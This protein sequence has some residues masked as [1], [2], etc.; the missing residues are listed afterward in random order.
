M[1][2]DAHPDSGVTEAPVVVTAAIEAFC[3]QHLPLV[4][5]GDGEGGGG[6]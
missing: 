2:N 1:Y 3:S 4:G 6:A 5:D